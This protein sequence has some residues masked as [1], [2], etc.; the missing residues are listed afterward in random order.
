MVIYDIYSDIRPMVRALLQEHRI[1]DI[2]L[3]NDSLVRMR[4][5]MEITRRYTHDPNFRTS[6]DFWRC[7]HPMPDMVL[8]RCRA[9]ATRIVILGKRNRDYYDYGE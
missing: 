8:S 5:R 6:M 9:I 4:I 7:I 2:I 1:H 3:L